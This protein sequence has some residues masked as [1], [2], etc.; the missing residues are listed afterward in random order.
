MSVLLR[1]LLVVSVSGCATISTEPAELQ[2]TWEAAQV[3]LYAGNEYVFGL[4]R[5]ASNQEQLA[6]I[7]AGLKL[8]T[9]IYLHGCLGQDMG[10]NDTTLGR[11]VREGF[12]VIA[13]DS[14]ALSNRVSVC[15]LGVQ[16]V[17]L[18]RA[19]EARY[20][21]ER[22]S[23]LP[24]VDPTNLFLI[25]HSEGGAGAATYTGNQ[26][27][28]IV[29]S[30]YHCR[31]GIG[32]GAPSLAVAYRDDPQLQGRIVC[33]GATERMLLEGTSHHP[34]RDSEVA[35]RVVAFIKSH[36]KR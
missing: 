18:A 20:A 35:D 8:P 34:M 16:Q 1:S 32:S 7:P 26:F 21:A 9:V 15:N 17:F 14:F 23:A 25:G 11:L 36:I 33:S 30:G 24:W 10:N 13:P 31:H 22:A 12:A 29:I 3:R 19:A 5:V 27:N 4:L 2:R 6:R 28:A